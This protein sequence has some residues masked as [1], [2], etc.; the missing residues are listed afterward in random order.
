MPDSSSSSDGPQSSSS[1]GIVSSSSSSGSPSDSSRSSSAV[2]SSSSSSDSSQSRSSSSSSSLSSSSSSSESPSSSSSSSSSSSGAPSFTLQSVSFWSGTGDGFSVLVDTTG[3]AYGPP[4]WQRSPL[5]EFPFLYIQGSKLRV[6]ATWTIHNPIPNAIYTVKGTCSDG[7]N[8]PQTAAIDTSNDIL[9]LFSVE[10]TTAFPANEVNF[11]NPLVIE[12][13][14]S[15]NGGDYVDAGTS[16]NPIY[17]CLTGVVGANKPRLFRSVVHLACSVTGATNL[18]EAVANTW[19]QLAGPANFCGWDDTSNAWERQLYYY[20]PGTTFSQNPDPNLGQVYASD[21][22]GTTYGG[23][24]RCFN[25]CW[26]F[27]DA[28]VLNGAYSFNS[29]GNTQSINISIAANTYLL[30]RGF[31]VFVGGQWESTD[32]FPERNF[33]CIN[34][35]SDMQPPPNLGDPLVYGEFKNLSS[36]PGQNSAPP[37]QKLFLNHFIIQY[38]KIS[39]DKVYYDPSYGVTYVDAADFQEKAL[40]GYGAAVA[41]IKINAMPAITVVTFTPQSLPY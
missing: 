27:Y 10:A 12:W 6:S 26:L 3:A 36:L 35:G 22:L 8:I 19:S 24:G 32:T 37:S 5:Q 29:S 17:V 41:P 21:L 11:Y 7:F 20:K 4:H 34:G 14:V 33:F 9:E 28:M 30:I 38:R 18:D 2:S 23:T 1:S 40:L 15:V 13:E 39:G 25:W 16:S 31:Q